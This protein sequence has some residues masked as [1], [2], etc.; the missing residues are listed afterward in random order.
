MY[1]PLHKTNGHDAKECKVLLAQV[2]KMSA[3]YE[4]K[5]SFHSNKHQKTNCNKSKSEQRFS[6]MVNAFKAANN[7]EK[8]STSNDNK[9]NTNENYAFDDDIIDEFNLDD[10]VSNKDEANSDSDE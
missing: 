10:D 3:S 9:R 1:C 6:F 5:T 4:S 8:N 7:K 2:N